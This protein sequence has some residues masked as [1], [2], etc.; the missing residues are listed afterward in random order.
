[1]V[2]MRNI[3][4]ILISDAM[5]WLPENRVL[6]IHSIMTKWVEVRLNKVILNFLSNFL[7]VEYAMEL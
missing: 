1:M 6:G 2:S 7:K 5:E 3:K 4:V